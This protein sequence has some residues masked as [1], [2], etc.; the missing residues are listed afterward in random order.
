MY[1]LH[2]HWINE[3]KILCDIISLIHVTKSI[4][5]NYYKHFTSKWLKAKAHQKC[6]TEYFVFQSTLYIFLLL[7][8]Q[9]LKPS[10]IFSYQIV[11]FIQNTLHV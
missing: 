2:S 1:I 8:M 3:Q 5:N 6:N 7:Q 11:Y 4:F 10:E 9:V